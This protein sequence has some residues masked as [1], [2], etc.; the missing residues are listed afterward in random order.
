MRLRT[1][2]I[3]AALKP[4]GYAWE[5]TGGGCSAFTRTEVEGS[6]M[7]YLTKHDDASAPSDFS[8]PVDVGTYRE[9][10]GELIGRI[11]TFPT[12]TAYI[13]TLQQEAK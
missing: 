11:R 4:Y 12:L 3:D 13:E 2:A 9:D 6:Y 1:G 7:T 10:V 5:W 8:D